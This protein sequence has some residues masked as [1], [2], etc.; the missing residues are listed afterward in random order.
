LDS[1]SSNS[2]IVGC[3]LGYFTSEPGRYEL[4][5]D[6]LSDSSWLNAAD[7]RMRIETFWTG[8]DE[9][10]T[11]SD[12]AFLFRTFGRLAKTLL[13]GKFCKFPQER[14]PLL[15]RLAR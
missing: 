1:S 5:V 2:P 13:A 3:F 14:A 4:D 12:A 7:P 8:Y 11:I 10:S 15:C 6:V 9:Y